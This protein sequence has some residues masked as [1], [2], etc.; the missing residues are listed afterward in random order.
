ML[1][2]GNVLVIKKQLETLVISENKQVTK[3]GEERSEAKETEQ[4]IKRDMKKKIEK[5]HSGPGF[6]TPPKY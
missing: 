1:E 4:I 6:V 3:R 2:H 5:D